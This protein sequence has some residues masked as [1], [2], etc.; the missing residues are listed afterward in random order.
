MIYEFDDNIKEQISFYYKNKDK[1]KIC[2]F[3]EYDSDSYSSNNSPI[4]RYGNEIISDTKVYDIIHN[5]IRS[6][7]NNG[8]ESYLSTS[9]ITPSEY[10]FH[11]LVNIHLHWFEYYMRNN[12]T[13]KKGNNSSI[14][15]WPIEKYDYRVELK[16]NKTIKSILSVRKDLKNRTKLFS[17]LTP[18]VNSIFRY[19]KYIT[20][21]IDENIHDIEYANQFPSW[22]ELQQEYSKSIFAFVIESQNVENSDDEIISLESNNS[23]CQISE[24]TLMAFMNGNIP[25]VLGSR[26]IVKLLK[27]I[28]LYTWNVEFGF[29]NGDDSKSYN[30]RIDSYVKCYNNIKELSFEDSKQYW[31]DNKDKIQKN[32]DIVSNLIVKKWN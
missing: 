14:L 7:R 29:G 18:D 20:N 15:A 32:Y 9:T 11:P 28:G 22:D 16:F 8:N 24:K 10:E 26:N 13:W 2:D 19:A 3:N 21:E 30:E 5:K 23:V 27:D 12:L 31:I 6:I 1:H 25:I 17:K 4:Y